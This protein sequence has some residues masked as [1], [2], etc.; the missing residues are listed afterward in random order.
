MIVPSS[1]LRYGPNGIL[2]TLAA[3]PVPSYRFCGF[4]FSA[5]GRL[6]IDTTVPTDTDVYINGFR[7]NAAGCLIGSVSG[8]SGTGVRNGGYWITDNDRLRVSDGISAP[9]RYNNGDPFVASGRLA[10]DYP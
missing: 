4:G 6:L 7:C 9:S 10:L 3:D 5:T 1:A 2:A 8:S